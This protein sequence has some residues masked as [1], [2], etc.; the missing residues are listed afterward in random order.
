MARLDNT[1]ANNTY[2]T[3]IAVET[4]FEDWNVWD[5]LGEAIAGQELAS[6]SYE[7]RG[8]RLIVTAH[9]KD[10]QGGTT[11][12]QMETS[13]TDQT[14]RFLANKAVQDAKSAIQNKWTNDLAPQ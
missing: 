7:E 11:V 14:I 10:G 2:K 3:M 6:L 9:I 13:L 4:V 5:D 8:D 12:F 1:L